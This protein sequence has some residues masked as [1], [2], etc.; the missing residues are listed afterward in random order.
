MKVCGC[1]NEDVE[2]RFEG[3]WYVCLSQKRKKVEGK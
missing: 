1:R 2:R 3:F